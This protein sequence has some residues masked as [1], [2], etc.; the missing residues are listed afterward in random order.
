M[1]NVRFYTKNGKLYGFLTEGHAE[2]GE[3]GADIVCAAVSSAAYLAAN[4]VT[5]ILK[6]TAAAKA[7]DGYLKFKLISSD[8]KAENVLKGYKLHIEGLREQYPGYIKIME[9]K[10]Q[11]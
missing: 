6:T 4:T 9:E 8:K 10:L 3:C 11:C 7:K 1:I 5:E 2:S